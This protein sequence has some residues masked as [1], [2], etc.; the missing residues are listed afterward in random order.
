MHLYTICL[1]QQVIFSDSLVLISIVWA[2]FWFCEP[3]FVFGGFWGFF[4]FFPTINLGLK[5]I[6]VATAD[7]CKSE[8]GSL[9][10]LQPGHILSLESVLPRMRSVYS[11]SIWMFRVFITP[12]SVF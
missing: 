9:L 6:F 5:H 8:C 7:A 12:M 3:G 4:F 2:P 10:T 11:D 1:T